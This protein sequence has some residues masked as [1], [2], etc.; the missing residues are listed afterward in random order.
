MIRTSGTRSFAALALL[1]AGCAP[2]GPAG[3]GQPLAPEAALAA[4]AM[5]L[6]YTL[7]IKNTLPNSLTVTL[8]PGTGA[9]LT[10]PPVFEIAQGKTKTAKLSVAAFAPG[11]I[12]AIDGTNADR[13][14]TLH[15]VISIV[16]SSVAFRMHGLTAMD[17]KAAILRNKEDS[18]VT[19]S[20]EA[21]PAAATPP[22]YRP[23]LHSFAGTEYSV[24][25]A[26]DLP[27]DPL[28]V[29]VT[30]SDHSILQG[31]SSFAIAPDAS[32]TVR[33][34]D[35]GS[36]SQSDLF[37]IISAATQE[38]DAQLKLLKDD[39]KGVSIVDMFQMQMAMN[40]LSQ[41]SEMSTSIVLASNSAITSMARGVK[42]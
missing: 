31:P 8:T 18:A 10:G 22:A 36:F 38:V 27:S 34:T 16:D 3:M 20:I 21:E 13:S 6:A 40:R 24:T 29:T 2:A 14:Q 12:V 4:E 26:N 28:D 32:E 37:D 42:S 1:V 35:V 41:L 9:T 23:G 39:G 33:I 5:P 25:L 19:V 11:Q 30:A 15:N 7:E 17:E